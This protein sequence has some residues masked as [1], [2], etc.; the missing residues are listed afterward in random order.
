MTTLY[1]SEPGSIACKVGGTIVV[2]KEGEGIAAYPVGRVDEVVLVGSGTHASGPLTRELLLRGIDLV[3]VTQRG[4]V[5]GRL[6]GQDSSS[7]ALRLTQLKR[8]GDPRF[9]VR[10]AKSFVR[11]K[12]RNQAALL[13]RRG[14]AG[15]GSDLL[16]LAGQAE[17]ASTLNELRGIEGAAGAAYFANLRLLFGP[18]PGFT[19]RRR[20]PPTDPVN[21]LLSF[22]YALLAKQVQQAVDVVGLDASLGFLHSPSSGRPSLVLDI[23]EEFRTLL[24][25]SFVIACFR[26]RLFLPS[27]FV[28]QGPNG[29]CRLTPHALRRFLSYFDRR[30]ERQRYSP[31]ARG[32]VTWRRR[33]ELQVRHLARVLSGEDDEYQP[34][35]WR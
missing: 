16:A 18:E 32:G 33:I 22:G 2:K 7:A 35:G 25:D 28:V 8:A 30:L 3:Y 17:T 31:L 11:G 12:L 19:G 27:D 23:M 34:L 10:M 13:Q 24:V 29:F 26:R 20:R 21:S 5:L 6:V 1:V 15:P 14:L 4:R 9:S